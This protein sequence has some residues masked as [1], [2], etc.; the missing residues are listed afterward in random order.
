MVYIYTDE[1]GFSISVNLVSGQ[2]IRVTH[3]LQCY[4]SQFSPPTEQ[5]SDSGLGNLK[6]GIVLL[7]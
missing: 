3:K 7:V 5:R 2:N 1:L 4:D 6:L